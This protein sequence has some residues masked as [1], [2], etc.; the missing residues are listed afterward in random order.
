MQFTDAFS[1]YL[2]SLKRGQRSIY[3]IANYRLRLTNLENF[4]GKETKIGDI[5]I[6]DLRSWI[7]NCL[8]RCPSP[9]TIWSMV[10]TVRAFFNWCVREE[11]LAHSPADRLERP[12][13][14]ERLPK[15]LNDQEIHALVKAAGS[16]NHPERDVALTC[17]FFLETGARRGAVSSLTA[18]NLFIED[19]YATAITKGDKEILLFFGEVTRSALERW[20]TIRDPIQFHPTVNPESVFGLHA[21][22]IRLLFQRLRER[23]K[24]QRPV[25]PHILRH[26]S[27]TLRVEQGID[28]SSLQ[29]IM[30]W[31][32]IRMAE[33][34][35]RL[36]RKRL[37]RRAL[38]TSPL[39]KAISLE[40]ERS[41]SH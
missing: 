5:S 36:A 8:E 32:D 35:T 31:S 22:G 20:L 39:D 33:V 9:H 17:F 37:R 21:D 11:L 29:Q 13:L 23:A 40:L 3:T 15:S 2:K 1:L 26:T 14:P 7:D 27:A 38:S 30:G 19:G 4:L 18:P 28:A 25:S 12:K 10:V 16:S 34:Y 41:G 6:H 24:I